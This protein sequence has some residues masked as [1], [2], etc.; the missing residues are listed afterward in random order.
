MRPL[1]QADLSSKTETPGAPNPCEGELY[2]SLG[3][4]TNGS[5]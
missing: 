2:G 5:G 1:E 3:T 4:I